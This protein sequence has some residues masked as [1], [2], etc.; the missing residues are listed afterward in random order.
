MWVSKDDSNAHCIYGCV[1]HAHSNSRGNNW[2]SSTE[3]YMSILCV[4]SVVSNCEWPPGLQP[5]RLFCPWDSPGKNN[6][7]G[8]HFLLQRIFLT[9][10]SNSRLLCLLH[11]QVDS[12][13]TTLPGKSN[14]NFKY[15]LFQSG[16]SLVAQSVK[17][18]PAVQET[19]SWSWVEK[20]LWRR[21]R[22]P[23]PVSL[24]GKSHGQSMGSQR[25]GHNW[26]TNTFHYYK[27]AL[28]VSICKDLKK[29][30]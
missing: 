4:C 8:C 9:Q 13:T 20:I 19:W 28:Q 2:I 5:A 6:P 15:S 30:L 18:L 11:W 12:F 3:F 29:I 25:V 26:A 16:A 10:E 23:T 1:V 7:V 17:N 14:V 21:K 27:V 24:P 22:Q